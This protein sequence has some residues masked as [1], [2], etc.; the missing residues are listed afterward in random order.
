MMQQNNERSEQDEKHDEN[1]EWDEMNKNKNKMNIKEV[2]V[3]NSRRVLINGDE[4]IKKKGYIL[5]VTEHLVNHIHFKIHGHNLE[6]KGNLCFMCGKISKKK[7]ITIHHALP[8]QLKSAYNV[9]IPLCDF[10]H[11]RLNELYKK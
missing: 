3:I 4:F 1:N 2:A 11:K 6:I 5:K 8:N 10:C 9:F 7:E